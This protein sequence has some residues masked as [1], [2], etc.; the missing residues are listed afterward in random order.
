MAA[1][2]DIVAAA[3]PPDADGARAVRLFAAVGAHGERGGGT[4]VRDANHALEIVRALCG[5]G[6]DEGTPPKGARPLW[7]VTVRVARTRRGCASYSCEYRKFTAV[8][9]E[10]VAEM[11]AVHREL[12]R[13]LR[14]AR[15]EMAA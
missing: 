7:V 8:P 5:D 14:R 1:Y 6:I 13:V 15:R 11:M 2:V 4:D 9:L 12:K 3:M 10:C